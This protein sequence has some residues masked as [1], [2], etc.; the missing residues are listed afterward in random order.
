METN[1]HYILNDSI[2]YLTGRVKREMTRLLTR[3]LHEAGGEITAEQYR[4]LMMLWRK[5][6]LNQQC[7]ADE[8][9]KDKAS[10]ARMLFTME[11]HGWITRKPSSD[12]KRNNLIYITDKGQEVRERYYPALKKLLAQADAAVS[13]EEMAQCKETLR[14]IINHFCQ[15]DEVN[16]KLEK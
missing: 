5:D 13:A 4:L 1:D 2:G 3:D 16:C 8:F 10:I 9:G 11:N 12:D 6:V 7:V 14:K 15:V